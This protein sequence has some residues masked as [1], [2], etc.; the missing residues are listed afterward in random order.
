MIIGNTENLN[1]D[2]SLD[3]LDFYSKLQMFE[4]LKKR[5]TKKLLVKIS[6]HLD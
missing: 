5:K 6:I 3:D 1:F 4:K 2:S